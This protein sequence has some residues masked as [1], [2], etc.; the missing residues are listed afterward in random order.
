MSRLSNQTCSH[1]RSPH[2]AEEPLVQIGWCRPGGGEVADCF[3]LERGEVDHDGCGV[4][5]VLAEQVG[6]RVSA[7]LRLTTFPAV[8]RWPVW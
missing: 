1:G 3:P 8:P 5:A 7:R 4:C 2:P 6:F